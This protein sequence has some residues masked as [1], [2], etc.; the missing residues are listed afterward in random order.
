MLLW[1][2]ALTA[3]ADRTLAAMRTALEAEDGER[4]VDL[5]WEALALEPLRPERYFLLATVSD[6]TGGMPELGRQLRALGL[7]AMLAQGRIGEAQRMTLARA[8]PNWRGDWGDTERIEEEADKLR[9]GIGVE[10]EAELRLK[11]FEFLR[12]F[13]AGVRQ[14]ISPMAVVG[15]LQKV[16]GLREL[17]VAAARNAVREAS[18]VRAEVAAMLVALQGA[19]GEAGV[20]GDLLRLAGRRE[21]PVAKHAE[22]A[23]A[24]VARRFPGEAVGVMAAAKGR[25][26]AERRV[27]MEVLVRLERPQGVGEALASLAEGFG[28]IAGEAEAGTLAGAL[29]EALRKRGQ[30][31]A[32]ELLRGAAPGV[33]RE[34]APAGDFRRRSLEQVLVGQALLEG[35]DVWEELD[36]GPA[37]ATFRRGAPKLGR[38]DACWCGSG[39]K[40][41]KC[42][43]DRDGGR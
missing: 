14:G 40:Y 26:A 30:R 25:S 33:V 2:D 32:A 17:L 16:A 18:G 20:M 12:D 15:V 41:K 7:E 43:M 6:E 1:N 10:L 37:V 5:G 38:N 9:I 22:W 35:G 13:L 24:Q 11:P 19:V 23:L 28:E 31:E 29:E 36:G 42:H 4:A 8:F 34:E 27:A 39:K 3:E 21:E